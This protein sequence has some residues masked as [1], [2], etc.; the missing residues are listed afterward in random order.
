MRAALPSSNEGCSSERENKKIEFRK[1]APAY[2]RIGVGIRIPVRVRVGEVNIDTPRRRHAAAHGT[3]VSF[4]R[5]ERAL[6]CATLCIWLQ[7]R[8]PVPGREPRSVQSHQFAQC[9]RA[10]AH[11]RTGAPRTPRGHSGGELLHVVCIAGTG[12]HGLVVFAER[13]CQPSFS[14]VTPQWLDLRWSAALCGADPA[15]DRGIGSALARCQRS[16]GVRPTLM[17]MPLVVPRG[18]RARWSSR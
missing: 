16:G 11:A 5:L 4:R 10:S 14:R 13:N 17:Q 1:R 9:T 8:V 6:P 18:S 15:A 12:R 3:P 2:R 7:K